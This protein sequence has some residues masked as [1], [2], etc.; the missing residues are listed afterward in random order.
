MSR[1]DASRPAIQH[2]R[3][4]FRKAVLPVKKL[5]ASPR[6]PKRRA[7]TRAVGLQHGSARWSLP[8]GVRTRLTGKNEAVDSVALSFWTA[9]G[10]LVYSQAGYPL[11]LA[12][13]SRATR[14][15]AR[16]P[17]PSSRTAM[18]RSTSRKLDDPI[19][20]FVSIIV[21]AYAEESVIARRVKN[22][23]ALDYPRDRFEVIVSCDG[24]PDRT[25]ERARAAGADVVLDHPARA[26]SGPRM[27]ASTG[28][29]GKSSHSV[30]PTASGS[31]ARCER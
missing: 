6:S 5:R 9:A 17:T 22:L 2:E 26:R 24:S 10:L 19:W 21:A 18:A 30:T 4:P 23:T 3:G 13:V 16:R 1:R 14:G 20:P 15:S 8:G 27:L 12:V 11:L 25:A 29:G 28:P 31:Q 7:A